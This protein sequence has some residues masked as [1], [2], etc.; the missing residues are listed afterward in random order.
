MKKSERKKR[1]LQV[2]L[3]LYESGGAENT[4]LSSVARADGVSQ[5]LVVKHF[6]TRENLISSVMREAVK[7]E[8]HKVIL[9]GYLV[10]H[11]VAKSAPVSVLEAARH[12]VF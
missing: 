5:A 1:L 9:A 10:G 3:S 4:T 2:A 12:A 8:N 11:P 7:R 6:K